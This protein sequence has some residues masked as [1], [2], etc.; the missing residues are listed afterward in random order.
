R[1]DEDHEYMGADLAIHQIG[2]YPEEATTIHDDGGPLAMRASS[3]AAAA[4]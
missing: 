1:L 4:E 2:A 3:R